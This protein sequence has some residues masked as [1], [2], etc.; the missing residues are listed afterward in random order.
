MHYQE[1]T[2]ALGT[3]ELQCLGEIRG[4]VLGVSRYRKNVLRYIA[5]FFH[6]IAI[7]CDTLFSVYFHRNPINFPIF[8]FILNLTHEN[9]NNTHAHM[10]V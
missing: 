8:A 5:I 2:I 3:T 9:Q 4:R 6:C 7:Y 10:S 1:N